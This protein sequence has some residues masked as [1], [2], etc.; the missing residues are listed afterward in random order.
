[1][2]WL[3]NKLSRGPM[4]GTSV[5]G[6]ANGEDTDEPGSSRASSCSN[7]TAKMGATRARSAREANVCMLE[8]GFGIKAMLD[9]EFSNKMG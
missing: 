8:F 4:L 5:V 3:E 7:G 1:M 2:S 9:R 6:A